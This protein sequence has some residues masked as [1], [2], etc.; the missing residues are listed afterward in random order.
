MPEPGFADQAIYDR[1]TER[2]KHGVLHRSPFEIFENGSE[3]PFDRQYEE[4]AYD[5]TVQSV[6][7][8][9]RAS[10]QSPS[11]G[12]SKKGL[13]LYP[14]TLIRGVIDWN[15][16]NPHTGIVNNVKDVVAM[17]LATYKG[18]YPSALSLLDQYEE[19]LNDRVLESEIHQAGDI[20]SWIGYNPSRS[21][22]KAMEL[23]FH[24]DERPLLFIALGQGAT[25]AGMDVFLHH[26]YITEIDNSEFYVV[27]FSRNKKKDV[28]P[29]M[30]KSE[31][32]YLQEAGKG[33]QIVL[34]EEDTITS[35]TLQAGTDFF[36][37]YVFPNQSVYPTQNYRGGN[38]DAY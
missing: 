14:P 29:A 18:D 26:S 25:A 28:R 22:R 13:A 3:L 38:G 8:D 33:R 34:F 11:D 1:Y 31:A 30:T 7:D 27:R 17:G 23:A 16:E 21:Y 5:G 37:R 2:I 24:F 19:S 9:L 20:A 10:L 15:V 6:I 4:L 36:R 12:I 35:N 32:E